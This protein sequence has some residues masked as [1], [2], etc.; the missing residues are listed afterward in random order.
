[1]PVSNM[2]PGEAAAQ[3]GILIAQLVKGTLG[4]QQ[5]LSSSALCRWVGLQQRSLGSLLCPC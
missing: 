4:V 2:V 5:L 1:M 3:F